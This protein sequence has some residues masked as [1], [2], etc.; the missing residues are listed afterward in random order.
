MSD[1]RIPVPTAADARP[2]R[3]HRGMATGFGLIVLGVLFLLHTLDVVDFRYS[4][5]WWPLLLVL[6]GV[7]RM[8]ERSD[9][10][11]GLWLVLIGLWLLVNEREIS[12]FTYHDSWPLLVVVVGL[13][14]V[15]TATRGAA[16][17][18]SNGEAQ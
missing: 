5:E 4:W 15:W 10:S 18:P 3:G 14:M 1:E 13:S 7:I 11:S 9:R 16:A 6:F 17:P 12:G 8:F 2:R